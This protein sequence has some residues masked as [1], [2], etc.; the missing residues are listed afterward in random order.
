MNNLWLNSLNFDEVSVIEHLQRQFNSN[1]I[2]VHVCRKEAQDSDLYLSYG[3]DVLT[4][5]VLS[6]LFTAPIG[7]IAV[8]FAGRRLLR[9]SS[10]DDVQMASLQLEPQDQRN[11][12]P[13]IET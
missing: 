13:E 8:A 11:S 9:K 2:F 12:P 4:T 5:A 6:I 10:V 3:S 7:A 1:V